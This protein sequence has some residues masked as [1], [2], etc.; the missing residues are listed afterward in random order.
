MA[1]SSIFAAIGETFNT[2]NFW[3]QLFDVCGPNPFFLQDGSLTA[4]VQT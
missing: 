3:L 4:S 2:A 1:A